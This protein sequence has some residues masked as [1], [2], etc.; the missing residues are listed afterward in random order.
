MKRCVLLVFILFSVGCRSVLSQRI[1]P[2]LT[3]LIL[4]HT[5]KAEAMYESQ[6]A[7]MGLIS[8]GHV[9]V[10]SEVEATKNFQKQFN[11]Y[12]TTFRGV[13]SFVAQIYGFYYEIDHLVKNMKK[14][15]EQLGDSPSNAI[16]VA[17][18]ANRN[19]IYFDIIQTGMG[20]IKN[21][22]QICFDGKMTEK[23]RVELLFDIRPKLKQLNHKLIV[24]T[25]LVKYTTLAHVWYDIKG[26]A[27]DVAM[28]RSEAI[29]NSLDAWKV[30]GKTVGNKVKAQSRY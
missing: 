27:R 21:I 29:K 8:E 28:S 19:D 12:I 3:L 26:G 13:V 7:A 18:H 22:R 30:N 10:N 2:V 5:K 11:D 17:L 1:D 24:L 20:V 9:F 4:D 14:M 16:A 23:E 25:K 15:T 6:S